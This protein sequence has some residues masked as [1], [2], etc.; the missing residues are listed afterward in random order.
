MVAQ[1][2]K[3]G[4][5]GDLEIPVAS[6]DGIVSPGRQGAGWVDHPSTPSLDDCVPAWVV[7][8]CVWKLLALQVWKVLGEE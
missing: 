1:L 3:A 7:W 6:A 4:W 2:G 8:T 5:G